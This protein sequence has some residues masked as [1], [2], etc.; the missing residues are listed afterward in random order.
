[1]ALARH[2]VV[3]INPSA[4]FGKNARVGDAVVAQVVAAGHEVTVCR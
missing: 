2:I 1:M 3:A 4:A